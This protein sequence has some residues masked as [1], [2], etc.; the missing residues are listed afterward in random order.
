MTISSSEKAYQDYELIKRIRIFPLIP[1][2]N[3]REEWIEYQTKT[4]D[5]YLN[6]YQ[7]NKEYILLTYPYELLDI[8]IH[9]NI[10]WLLYDTIKYKSLKSYI[11]WSFYDEE[12]NDI[13]CEQR[14]NVG[15]ICDSTVTTEKECNLGRCNECAENKNSYE[16][17][18]KEWRCVNTKNHPSRLLRCLKCGECVCINHIAVLNKIKT[19]N[20]YNYTYVECLG[21]SK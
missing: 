9:I 3:T 12:N 4:V 6:L 2:Y 21:C 5:S 7:I 17:D 10:V 16:E 8:G 13:A 15:S 20:N 14:N 11:G 1:N 18:E 19:K